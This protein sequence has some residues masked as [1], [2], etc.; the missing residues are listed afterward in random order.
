MDFLF[1][2]RRKGFPL[3]WALVA[4]AV[5]GLLCQ[6]SFSYAMSSAPA[7]PDQLRRMPELKTAYASVEEEI[8]FREGAIFLIFAHPDDELTILAEVARLK[9][10]FPNRAVHWLL[11]SDAA[12][13][14][15]LPGTCGLKSK[16][17]CRYDEAARAASCVGISAPVALGYPDGG[18]RQVA[19]LEG[20][21]WREMTGLAPEG[22][23]V[24]FTSDEAGLYGH[25]D[26]LAIHDAVVPRALRLGIPVVTGALTELMSEKIPL[27]EPALSEGRQRPMITHSRDLGNQDQQMAACAARSHR[28]QAILIWNFMQFETP[29][30][31]Y[32]N[33]PRA[34]MNM[35]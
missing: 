32:R 28:S 3:S 29:E 17:R 26:H 11:V 10:V 35:R 22:I 20:L 21:L 31:F 4:L 33:V 15:T 6:A 1:G 9:R 34:F 16:S 14:M 18:L 7:R 23:S 2:K 24:I 13:G 8:R 30:Q 25:A 12:K 5:I 19:D 27:R